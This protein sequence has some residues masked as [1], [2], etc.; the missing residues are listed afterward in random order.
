MK[1]VEEMEGMAEIKLDPEYLKKF[2]E[3]LCWKFE[4]LSTISEV[5]AFFIAAIYSLFL[6]R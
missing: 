1:A 2:G 3:F 5:F 6:R 4:S